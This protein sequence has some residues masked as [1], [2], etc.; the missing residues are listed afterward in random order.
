MVEMKKKKMKV[1]EMT[2]VL[3]LSND[4]LVPFPWTLTTAKFLGSAL[5]IHYLQFL[6]SLS[7][8]KPLQSSLHPH[9]LLKL[10]MSR[11][12]APWLEIMLIC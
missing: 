5:C 11:V 6:S 12:S 2:S 3:K 8:L 9:L 10:Q 1:V 7:L 4:S